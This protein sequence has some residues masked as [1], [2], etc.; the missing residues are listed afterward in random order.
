MTRSSPR[1]KTSASWMSNSR[2]RARSESRFDSI[3]RSV[4][5][6]TSGMNSSPSSAMDARS[7]PRSIASPTRFRGG[8]YSESVTSPALRSAMSSQGRWTT[9]PV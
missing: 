5:R 8:T 4:S 1:A 6:S 9:G 2:L 3:S 7:F